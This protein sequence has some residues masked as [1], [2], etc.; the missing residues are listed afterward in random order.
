MP[1]FL[2]K[3][4]YRSMAAWSQM[5]PCNDIT[6]CGT[7]AAARFTCHHLRVTRPLG[8]MLLQ[9]SQLLVLQYTFTSVS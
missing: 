5:Q 8:L 7:M 9:P 3:G 4:E 6:L 1:D 2:L